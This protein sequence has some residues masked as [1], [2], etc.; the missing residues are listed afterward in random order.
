VPFAVAWV[1]GALLVVGFTM[2]SGLA[3]LPLASALHLPRI[4]VWLVL[5]A[6]VGAAYLI[7]ARAAWHGRF[8][9]R[10]LAL[11]GLVADLVCG[12]FGPGPST[13]QLDHLAEYGVTADDIKNSAA[14]WIVAGCWWLVAAVA[15]L[16][17]FSPACRGYCAVRDNLRGIGKLP[18]L[19]S[20]ARQ[21]PSMATAACV[22]ALIGAGFTVLGAFGVGLVATDRTT[23]AA[24]ILGASAAGLM[25]A[26]LMSAGL[27]ATTAV[28]TLHGMPWA[29]LA[30]VLQCITHFWGSLSGL[31][32]SSVFGSDDMGRSA[33]G[34][35]VIL[36]IGIVAAPLVAAI[37]LLVKDTTIWLFRPPPAWAV[38]AK[39]GPADWFA[40]LSPNQPPPPKPRSKDWFTTTD[41]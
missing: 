16:F 41:L 35:T 15:V 2:V 40:H 18:R 32:D 11:A 6:A 36:M 20:A 23:S 19:F 37:Q 28:F 9:A 5:G 1:A 10:W 39:K 27:L 8:W 12:V 38:P 4:G 21:R 24:S 3:F 33:S 26:G 13:Q 7:A 25:L 17:A 31:I 22:L 34:F 30:L 14:D 29:W